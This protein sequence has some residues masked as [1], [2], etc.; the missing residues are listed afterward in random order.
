MAGGPDLIDLC[1]QG[2]VVAV[3][4]ERFHIL[5]MAGGLPLQPQASAA[6]A[7]IGHESAVKCRLKG[8]LI[9]ISQH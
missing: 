7:V 6:S 8:F 4:G 1:Q 2:I 5:V 9:H 3:Q